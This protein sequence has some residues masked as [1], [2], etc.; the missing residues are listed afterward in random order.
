MRCF[1]LSLALFPWTY[2]KALVR[3][4]AKGQSGMSLLYR[5]MLLFLVA[6]AP[7]VA[8]QIRE[9]AQLSRMREAEVD[10][11]ARRYLS[12]IVSE[13]NR[14]VE[15]IRQTLHVLS[16]TMAV[17]VG[18]PATCQ[19]LLSRVQDGHDIYVDLYVAGIDGLVECGTNEKA[20]GLTIA[21]REHFR[22][23]VETRSFSTGGYVKSRMD[24]QAALPFATPAFDE[25]GRMDRVV[26]AVLTAGWLDRFL[27]NKVL[28]EG[29][30]V[31]LADRNGVLLARS[32]SLE[33][34]VGK[35]LPPQYAPMI[36][37]TAQGVAN[38]TSIDGTERIFAYSPPAADPDGIAVIVGFDREK[39][40]AP[41]RESTRRSLLVFVSGL[42]VIVLAT[43]VGGHFLVRRPVDALVEATRRWRAGDFTARSQIRSRSE[44]GDLARAFDGLAEDLER[45]TRDRERIESDLL[46]NHA[47]L[48]RVLDHLPIGAYVLD[49]SGRILRSNPTAVRIWG[50]DRKVG[51]DGYSEYKA[52][53]NGTGKRLAAEDWGAYHAIGRGETVL[54]QIIDIE[55]FD[56]NRRTIRNSAVPIVASDQE[57]GPVLGAVVLVEDITD[58]R[59]A[60]RVM[61][62]NLALLDTIIESSTDPIFVMDSDGRFLIANTATAHLFDREPCEV[63]G[64]VITDLLPLEVAKALFSANVRVMINRQAEM[65]EETIWSVGHCAPR[66]FH[67]LKT[68]LYDADGD[69][70]GVIGIARDITDLKHA[71]SALRRSMEEAERANLAKSKFLAAASHDLRQPL[72]SLFLFTAALERDVSSARGID[73]LHCIDRGLETLKALLDSLLDVSRLDAG[74]IEPH[75][76]P[77]CAHTLINDIETAYAG[78]AAA[79]G[80]SLRVTGT[81]S[82]TLATDPTLLGR[83][84]RNLVENAIRYTKAGGIELDCRTLDGCVAIRVKD[85]GIGIPEDHLERI[86]EEFHQV[87]NSARDRE[88]GLGLGLAIVRRLSNLLKH[89]VQVHSTF[90]VGS[91]FTVY[92]PLAENSPAAAPET[93]VLAGD[94]AKRLRVLVVDDDSMVLEALRLI[95]ETWDFD[96]LAA[97]SGAAALEAVGSST[98][99]LVIA[100]YRLRDGEIGINVIR[101]VRDA[102]GIQVP[103]ILLTGETS[104]DFRHEAERLGLGLA[105]KPINPETLKNVIVKTLESIAGQSDGKQGTERQAPDVPSM[106]VTDHAPANC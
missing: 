31:T 78:V 54:D 20:I 10:E 46:R 84:I 15:G 64:A 77:V 67:T 43:A 70:I 106:D 45:Q 103:G 69:V 47:L 32:P 73:I 8:L 86:F 51:I 28:P 7:V 81:S 63:V 65:I 4:D 9:D 98:L 16:H 105:H 102:M 37:G 30:V 26:T 12:M 22:R 29:A 58:Q 104:L 96:V 17:R 75:F 89:P 90:G 92:V 60:E 2:V 99:D 79:A 36:S 14:V 57:N 11:Q 74:A 82:A 80:L 55:T 50:G 41:L 91:E 88:K 94:P 5:L 42:I 101:R 49:A 35:P 6:L 62:E 66:H 93:A 56:G 19:T 76:Q 18:N 87:G 100:D 33:E 48:D 71:E 72:Q 1:L 59:T 38:L 3:F 52:W 53:W 23:A 24:G 25:N 97:A 83:M 68:P 27:N 21:D 39:A 85:T 95:L 40:L 34:W 44:I 13:Q 61:Q